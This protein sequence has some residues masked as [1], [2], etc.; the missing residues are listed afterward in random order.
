MPQKNKNERWQQWAK[1]ERTSWGQITHYKKTL[2][3]YNLQ[4]IQCSAALHEWQ[5]T[6]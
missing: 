5:N 3:N 4:E 6:L 2:K 1:A